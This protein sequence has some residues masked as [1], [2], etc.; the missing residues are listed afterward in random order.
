MAGPPNQ[1]PQRNQISCKPKTSLTRVQSPGCRRPDIDNEFAA[2]DL[3]INKSLVAHGIHSSLF[4]WHRRWEETMNRSDAQSSGLH[5]VV[6]LQV[7]RHV[8]S[9]IHVHDIRIK[10]LPGR[11]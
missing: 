10:A 3:W 7:A 1:G 6:T 4:P 11:S 5:N 8:W 2:S 9:G